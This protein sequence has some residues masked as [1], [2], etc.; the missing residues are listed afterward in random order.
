MPMPK[1]FVGKAVS[2]MDQ[3]NRGKG[4]GRKPKLVRKWIKACNISKDDA[5]NMLLSL[6]GNYT[7]PELQELNKSEADKVSVLTYAFMRQAIAAAEKNDFSIMNQM[8]EFIY[9]K[10]EQPIKIQ[11]DTRLVD[12]KMLLSKQCEESPGEMER[13]VDGLEEITGDA[14]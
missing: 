8:L 4:A 6:L 5:R 1:H 10:D 9:G 11:A 2:I 14:K 13:I 7:L 12:L 3:P